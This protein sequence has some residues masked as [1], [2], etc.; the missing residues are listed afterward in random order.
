MF[1][2]WA[3]IIRDDK[4]VHN[5]VLEKDDTFHLTRL[6]L[7]LAEICNELDIETPVILNK[8]MEH[9]YLFNLTTFYQ[10]DFI[11][12]VNFDK[13]VIENIS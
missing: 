2:I 10:T 7:Y 1:K 13:L 6:S 4:I 12:S 9:F 11:S 3:K 5:Y 8:H